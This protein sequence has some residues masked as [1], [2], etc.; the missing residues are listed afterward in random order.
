MSKNRNRDLDMSDVF[1]DA[2]D[3]M[4]AEQERLDREVGPMH[5]VMD[6]HEAWVEDNYEIAFQ[7]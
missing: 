5:W 1:A 6:E 2:Y 7:N 4:I 3:M